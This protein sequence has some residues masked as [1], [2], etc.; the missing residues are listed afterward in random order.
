MKGCNIPDLPQCQRECVQL[1]HNSLWR[2]CQN[3]KAILG[4]QG[5]SCVRADSDATVATRLLTGTIEIF[6][7]RGENLL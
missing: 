4:I 3:F 5:E 1:Y 6:D 7:Y 2:P